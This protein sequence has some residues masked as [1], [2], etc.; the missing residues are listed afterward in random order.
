MFQVVPPS[1]LYEN[2]SLPKVDDTLYHEYDK[3][4][5]MNATRFV[6]FVSNFISGMKSTMKLSLVPVCVELFKNIGIFILTCLDYSVFSNISI[7]LRLGYLV[8]LVKAIYYIPSFIL[9]GD[10]VITRVP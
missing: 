5:A 8:I 2:R 6:L 4:A 7:V 10:R 3:E 1:W 9:N